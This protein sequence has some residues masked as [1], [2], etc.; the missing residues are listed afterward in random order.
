LTLRKEYILRAF[1]NRVLRGIFGLKR[2]E[3]TGEWRKLHNEK[4]VIILLISICDWG[5]G[6]SLVYQFLAN[7]YVD[8]HILITLHYLIGPK[9]TLSTFA[10]HVFCLTISSHLHPYKLLR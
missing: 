6:V 9:N 1:E 2:D 7:K 3:V 8:Y 4:L 5:G 10:V